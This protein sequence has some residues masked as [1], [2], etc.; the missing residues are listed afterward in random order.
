MAK[1][2]ELLLRNRKIAP[3]RVYKHSYTQ[4]LLEQIRELE[5]DGLAPISRA[6]T[7]WKEVT[8]GY[9]AAKLV[10]KKD[11]SIILDAGTGIGMSAYYL[12]RRF[13]DAKVIGVDILRTDRRERYWNLI[14]SIAPN[15]EFI[16]GDVRDVAKNISPN[17]VVGV[18]NCKVLSI[19]DIDIAAENGAD[20]LLVPCCT[21]F[22]A[23]KERGIDLS[24]MGVLTMTDNDK[25]KLWVIGLAEYARKKGLDVETGMSGTL[26]KV[27]K[28]NAYVRTK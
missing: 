11:Y 21:D 9:G 2:Y 1:Y 24:H 6:G 16:A 10:K 19:Y 15:V 14:K 17:L 20:L 5:N 3:A 22:D 28:K 7:F 23:L 26:E 12:A 25:Y 8:E 27:T 18:H 4:D 13:P